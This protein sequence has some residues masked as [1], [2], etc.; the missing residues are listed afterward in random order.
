MENAAVSI[1]VAVGGGSERRVGGG[2]GS[3][4]GDQSA[5]GA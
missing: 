1:A 4:W 5:V 2:R 3:G